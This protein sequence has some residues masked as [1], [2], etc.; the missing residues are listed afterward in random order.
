MLYT[1]WCG[2]LSRMNSFIALPEPGSGRSTPP[3]HMCVPSNAIRRGP[4]LTA[5]VSGVMPVDESLVP[6]PSACRGVAMERQPTD[7]HGLLLLEPGHEGP[8]GRPV[9]VVGSCVVRE[10]RRA[11]RRDD[12]LVAQ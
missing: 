8:N 5:K 7:F 6:S 4:L 1:P 12:A 9:G 2:C 11:D 3:L 10:L